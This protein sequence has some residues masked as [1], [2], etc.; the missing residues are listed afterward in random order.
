MIRFIQAWYKIIEDSA[1]YLYLKLLRP[2]STDDDSRRRESILNIILLSSL[3]LTFVL[4]LT[5]LYYSASLGSAYKGISFSSFSLIV[6]S[7]LFL[8]ILSRRGHFAIAAYLVVG[9]YFAA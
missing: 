4:D 3:I 2:L 6:L 7:F 9:L 5:V 8:Y 1:C